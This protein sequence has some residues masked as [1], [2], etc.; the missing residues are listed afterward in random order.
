MKPFFFL[1]AALLLLLYGSTKIKERLR[2]I[3]HACETQ[4]RQIPSNNKES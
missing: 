4:S 2:Q 1:G 3:W